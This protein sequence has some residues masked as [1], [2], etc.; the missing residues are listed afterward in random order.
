MRCDTVRVT[1]AVDK[2]EEDDEAKSDQQEN[3]KTGVMPGKMRDV[4]MVAVI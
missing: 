3:A 2:K 4:L 1:Q